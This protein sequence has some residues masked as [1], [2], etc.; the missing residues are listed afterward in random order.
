MNVHGIRIGTSCLSAPLSMSHLPMLSSVRSLPTCF[1]SSS[2]TRPVSQCSLSI[3]QILVICSPLS[4]Y[5][6]SVELPLP[7][8]N[9]PDWADSAHS[10]LPE[11]AVFCGT[12]AVTR[13]ARRTAKSYN[14]TCHLLLLLCLNA[15]VAPATIRAVSFSCELEWRDTRN[16][17]WLPY[18]R[19][20]ACIC[21]T[22]EREGGHS[23]VVLEGREGGP[24]H[25][26]CVVDGA[27]THS[28]Q[29]P[30][31]TDGLR[32]VHVCVFSA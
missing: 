24:A 28:V 1:R 21:Y 2:P 14:T 27:T 3:P 8:R 26:H 5:S 31:A 12:W 18:G 20:T 13:R 30:G 29:T 4:G 7:G 32:H 10:L 16:V 17:G 22:E 15:H 6:G 19:A 11:C 23:I 25:R 9:R